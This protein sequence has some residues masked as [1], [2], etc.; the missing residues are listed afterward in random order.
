[1]I[2]AFISHS[3]KQKEEFVEPL[4]ELLGR[5]SCIIDAY[6][7]ESS[8]KSLDEIYRNIDKCSIFVFLV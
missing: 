8:Y 5:D 1:M 3:S 4:A 7:F 2:K 6:D